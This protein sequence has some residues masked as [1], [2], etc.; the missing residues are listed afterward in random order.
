M[1]EEDKMRSF[2]HQQIKGNDEQ[3]ATL[4]KDL[5]MSK[6]WKKRVEVAEKI[7][8]GIQN[9]LG[10]R[11]A[12]HDEPV[13]KCVQIKKKGQEMIGSLRKENNCLKKKLHAEKDRSQITEIIIKKEKKDS[14]LIYNTVGEIN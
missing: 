4:T 10:I 13:N 1:E 14:S 8:K 12:K 5:E 6:E 9:E 11:I 2:L 7:A 3:L